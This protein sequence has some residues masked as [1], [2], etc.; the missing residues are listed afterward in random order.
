MCIVDA[1]YAPSFWIM[2]GQRVTDPVWAVRIGSHAPHNHLH[3]EP[4][5]DFSEEAVE[6][7][8]SVEILA[9]TGHRSDD[10]TY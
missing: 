5:A 7:E 1:E 9:T 3:P 8:E 2:E 6:V 4:P 10:I